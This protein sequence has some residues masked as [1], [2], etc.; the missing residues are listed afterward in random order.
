[1]TLLAQVHARPRA[2]ARRPTYPT[3]I[4]VTALVV[5]ACAGA[6]PSV[7]VDPT[8]ARTSEPAPVQVVVAASPT[9][10][11]EAKSLEGL[12]DETPA[13]FDLVM[14]AP[15]S[16]PE[17]TAEPPMVGCGGG[18][19]PAYVLSTQAKDRMQITAR[20]RYCAK[21]G[22]ELWPGEPAPIAVAAKIDLEGRAQSVRVE[23]EEAIPAAIQDCVERL[24]ASAPFDHDPAFER[25]SNARVEPQQ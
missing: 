4:S 5:T 7:P 14:D 21:A 8:S 3:L 18:C 23:G 20:V 22:R 10:P 11:A 12:V 16:F 24:V 2:A 13:E 17:D 15:T 6:S 1:M 25:T 9:P 19:P